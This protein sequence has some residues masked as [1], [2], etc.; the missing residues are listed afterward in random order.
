MNSIALDAPAKINLYLDVLS[1]RADG[2]HNIATVFQR[3]DLC[4]KVK[5]TLMF[6][7][8][9]MTHV[10]I[11]RNLM[12]RLMKELS[13]VAE[14]EKMPSLEGRFMVMIMTPK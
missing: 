7:G 14:V 10:D 8:R 6:R 5:V 12:N 11:G 1:K 9:E 13:E 2:Y 3:I 4:D